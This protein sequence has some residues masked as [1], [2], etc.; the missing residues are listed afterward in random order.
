[1]QASLSLSSAHFPSRYALFLSFL[2]WLLLLLRLCH[3]FITVQ[4]YVGTYRRPAL[5]HMARF[6]SFEKIEWQEILEDIAEDIEPYLT[7]GKVASYIP[8][9]AKVNPNQ[10]GIAFTDITGRTY[11]AGQNAHTPFSIQSISKVFALVMA[12][13]IAGEDLW[14]IVGREPSGSAFNSI[15]QLENEKG[16]PRNPFINAGAIVITNTVYRHYSTVND[17]EDE[18]DN[19]PNK[20]IQE[21][22]QNCAQVD[23]AEIRMDEEVAKSEEF[24]GDRNRAL[25]YF[26]RSHG[27]VQGSIHRTLNTYFHQCA[28]EMSAATLSRA[29]LFLA[30][31]GLNPLNQDNVFVTS[32]DHVNRVNSIM[33]LCGHYDMSGDFAF[34]VGLAGK[35]GVGGYVRSQCRLGW[36]GLVW[37]P[38]VSGIV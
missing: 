12:L 34:R 29:G 4:D 27:I 32:Q 9:L 24:Y 2:C 7:K 25:A 28:L 3:G 13:D 14:T 8:A 10:F 20:R 36:S 33:M 35:S 18:D 16:R 23:G 1:M 38:L 17:D 11:T 31:G 26:M 5:L 6:Q 21:F 37:S 30:A 22:I 15:V 19:G